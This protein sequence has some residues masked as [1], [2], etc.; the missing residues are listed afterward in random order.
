MIARELERYAK[1]SARDIIEIDALVDKAIEENSYSQLADVMP[2]L[3]D[4]RLNGLDHLKP[5]WRDRISAFPERVVEKFRNLEESSYRNDPVSHAEY[6]QQIINT[7]GKSAFDL[8]KELREDHKLP[9]DFSDKECQDA[10]ATFSKISDRLRK[11]EERNAEL[12]SKMSALSS[13]KTAP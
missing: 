13:P 6:V 9:T 12:Q 7:L 10:L 2:S 3:A 4:L 8:G 1:N 5:I 11:H